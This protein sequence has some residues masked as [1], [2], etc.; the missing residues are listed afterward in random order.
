MQEVDD[1]VAPAA[2]EARRQVD[3][4]RAQQAREGSAQELPPMRLLSRDRKTGE[5]E[6]RQQCGQRVHPAA[7]HSRRRSW[8]RPAQRALNRA[9]QIA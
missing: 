1:W 2:I 6:R 9:F 7:D 8:P 4:A 3:V 5:H